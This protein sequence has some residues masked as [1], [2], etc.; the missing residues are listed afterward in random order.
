MY[1]RRI[2]LNSTSWIYLRKA[3]EV[4]RVH[5]LNIA[6]IDYYICPVVVNKRLSFGNSTDAVA[7]M[8]LTMSL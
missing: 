3:Q 4:R 8:L 5:A 7:Y 1:V 2:K 6:A